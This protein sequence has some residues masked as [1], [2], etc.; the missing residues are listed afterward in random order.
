MSV[1]KKSKN[2]ERG[3]SVKVEVEVGEWGLRTKKRHIFYPPSLIFGWVKQRQTID[4]VMNTYEN[5][6]PMADL[7]YSFDWSSTPLGAMDT[8]STSL[9]ANVDLCMHAAFPMAIYYGPENTL[10][11]NQMWRPILKM[12]HPYALGK[13]LKEVWPE[14]REKLEKIFE[15][16]Y[17]TKKGQFNEDLLFYLN[18]EGY[19]EETYFSF[20]FSPIFK[21]DGTVGGVFNCVQETTKRVITA[22]R[23]KVLGE[24]GRLTLGAKSIEGACHLVTATL[25]KHDADIPYALLYLIED[26]ATEYA[27]TQFARLTATTFDQN[28]DTQI[29]ED[30]VEEM[31]FV[32]GHSSRELPDLLSNT[33]NLVDITDIENLHKSTSIPSLSTFKKNTNICSRNNIN[34]EVPSPSISPPFTNTSTTNKNNYDTIP[35]SSNQP[36]PIHQVIQTNSHVVVNLANDSQA[37]MLPVS[38]SI[39][40]K[41]ILNAIIICGLN[42]HCALDET[43]ME[44]LQLVANHFGTGLSNGRSREEER[45]NTEML[46][47]LNR[48]KIMFFQNISHELRTPLTLML[49]PLEDVITTC[50]PSSPIIQDLEMIRRNARRLLKLVNTLLQ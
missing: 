6:T 3:F 18:R 47:D 44:F 17:A 36:W 42:T 24:L 10:I 50:S 15:D 33:Q 2:S 38:T 20:T 22:R 5:E 31:K 45:K 12:K 29:V 21:K 8:W 49:A 43:Y 14:V 1:P 19:P 13:T 16:V 46:A 26:H 37:I 7:V 23:L 34:E 9:R 11:Y 35:I 28:L 30:G 41:N 48:Q 32:D 39:G 25:R 4:N 40:G 27:R